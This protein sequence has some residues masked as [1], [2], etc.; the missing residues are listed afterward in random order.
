MLA[1]AVFDHYALLSLQGTRGG[2]FCRA[3]IHLAS[4]SPGE[5]QS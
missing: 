5:R 1:V 4:F 2:A 3:V